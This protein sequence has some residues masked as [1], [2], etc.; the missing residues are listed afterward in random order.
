MWRRPTRRTETKYYIMR[1]A[2]K[3]C[4]QKR[5]SFLFEGM[6]VSFICRCL[7]VF[8]DACGGM[9]G[10]FEGCRS[11]SVFRMEHSRDD[12][13]C[14]FLC[15][16]KAAKESLKGGEKYEIPPPFKKPTPLKRPT[17]GL[18]PLYGYF[19]RGLGGE[20]ERPGIRPQRFAG[21]GRRLRRNG[22]QETSFRHFD[23]KRRPLPCCFG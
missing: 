7:R 19:P 15:G 21:G 16:Q 14:C 18:R 9:R 20:T 11:F 6:K 3:D 23:R 8:S 5:Q 12:G 17:G 13:F 2:A 22:Q 1:D 10:I 4:C